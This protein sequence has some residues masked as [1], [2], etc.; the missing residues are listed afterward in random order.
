MRRRV[1]SLLVAA[2]IVVGVLPVAV[3]VQQAREDGR[4][5]PGSDW[6][7]VGGD[8]TSGRYSTLR[9]I[10]TRNVASLGGAWMKD[11]GAAASTRATPV[12]KNGVMFIPAGA[13]LHA[14]DA[15][16]GAAIWTWPP[17]AAS[18]PGRAPRSPMQSISGEELPNVAG[19]A[20][21]E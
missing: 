4:S 10:D 14:I 18:E 11:F 8:W 13:L 3:S 17:P 19:V 1:P 16:T 7:L 2:A 20:D 15:K 9:Q 21:S 5:L 6:P 12:V